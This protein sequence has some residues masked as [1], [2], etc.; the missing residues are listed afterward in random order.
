MVLIVDVHML[1]QLQEIVET[2]A[3]Y[4][5]APALLVQTEGEDAVGSRTIYFVAVLCGVLPH[6]AD[7]GVRAAAEAT[8]GVGNVDID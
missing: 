1:V 4:D 7:T 3:A 6:V 5:A 2:L 8:R